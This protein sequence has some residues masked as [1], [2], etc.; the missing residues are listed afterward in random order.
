LGGNAPVTTNDTATF[1][2]STNTSPTLSAN[3]TIDSIT[4]NS[5]AGAFSIQTN[6]HV[7][8]LLGVGIVNNSG[9]VQTIINST[10]VDVGVG[11]T[12]FSNGATADA[13][14]I[15]N[16]GVGTSTQFLNTSTAANATIINSGAE[17]Y[18]LFGAPVPSGSPP[19]LPGAGTA[20]N[21]T[22]TNSGDNSFTAFNQA[23]SGGNAALIN[24]NPTAFITIAELDGA[25]TTVGS[26]A[27]NGTIYLGSKNL[28]VGGNQQSTLF[29]GVISDG[30]APLLPDILR[31][32]TGPFTGGSLTKVG[33]GTLTL[34]GVNSYTGGTNLNGGILAVNSDV[35]LGTGALSFNGAHSRRL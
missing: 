33:T 18:T 26:I 30:E 6:G 31:T 16:S 14:L 7:L 13:T 4:F 20:A 5:N 21:A 17:S 27:G 28:T 34:T 23:A 11:Q 24:A 35:N 8:T 9:S 25:G 12:I 1:D 10:V 2:T 19:P 32:G 22:I 3:V 15:V 29:S